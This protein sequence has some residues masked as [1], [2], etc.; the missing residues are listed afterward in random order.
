MVASWVEDR[1]LVGD[2][3][4]AP[5][6]GMIG[7]CQLING[8]I[9][10]RWIEDVEPHRRSAQDGGNFRA[11]IILLQSKDES[12]LIWRPEYIVDEL[13]V[14]AVFVLE[15]LLNVRLICQP[16]QIGEGVQ[17]GCAQA[18]LI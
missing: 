1:I 17:R 15:L 16:G 11:L 9:G 5:I 14:I 12:F 13:F 10:L 7:A 8:G 4:H 2:D 6:C 3:A 18:A